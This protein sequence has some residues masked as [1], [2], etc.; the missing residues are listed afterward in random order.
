MEKI[1]LVV[2]SLLLTTVT[3]VARADDFL[4]RDPSAQPKIEKSRKIDIFLNAIG[5]N[6]TEVKRLVDAV[7]GR[8]H[9]GYLHLGEERVPGGKLVLHYELSGGVRAKQLELRFTPDDSHWQATART[10]AVMV[11]YKL[12]F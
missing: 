6:G 9:D 4:P 1:G 7:D 11:N 3:E 8:V 5:A 10:D 12:K 2:A